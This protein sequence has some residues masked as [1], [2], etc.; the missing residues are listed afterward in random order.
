MTYLWHR[1]AC[2]AQ[3]TSIKEHLRYAVLLKRVQAQTFSSKRSL[4]AYTACNKG[5]HFVRGDIVVETEL[6]D[7]AL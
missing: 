3:S 1:V 5:S 4:E 6:P 7:K 2:W